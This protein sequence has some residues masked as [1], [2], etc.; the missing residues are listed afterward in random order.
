MQTL[1]GLGELAHDRGDVDQAAIYFREALDLSW[2]QGDSRTLTWSLLGLARIALDW[3]QPMLAAQ[4]CGAVHAIETSL[5]M[6]TSSTASGVGAFVVAAARDVLG[7]EA[8]ARVGSGRCLPLEQVV[9]EARTLAPSPSSPGARDPISPADR[10][11]LSSRELEVLRLIV[12]GHSNAEI[13]QRLFI[14]RRTATTHVTHLYAKLDVTSRA[15]AIA[16][17]HRHHLI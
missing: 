12:A 4:L 9:A 1:G 10:L 5:A 6:V 17:A 11:G 8:F 13:A 2:A 14:S 15:Q 3:A 16:A 7:D